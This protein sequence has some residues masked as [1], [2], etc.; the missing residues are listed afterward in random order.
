MK[1]AAERQLQRSDLPW[2]IVRAEAFLELYQ[3]AR[4][5]A[6]DHILIAAHHHISSSLPR[7]NLLRPPRSATHLSGHNDLARPG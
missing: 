3:S 2:T 7:L 6:A 5:I 1:A 4:Y